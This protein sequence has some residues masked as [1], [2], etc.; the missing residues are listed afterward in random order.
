[1]LARSPSVA[2]SRRPRPGPSN[3]S[4]AVEAYGHPAVLLDERDAPVAPGE[5][6]EPLHRLRIALDVEV[7]DPH[8]SLAEVLT[9]GAGVGSGILAV[10]PNGSRRHGHMMPRVGPKRI[11]FGSR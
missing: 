11:A 5:L 7:L 6:E 10:N 2:A 9:G 1:M 3:A 8:P 4:G